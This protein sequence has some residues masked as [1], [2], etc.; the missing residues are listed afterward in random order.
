MGYKVDQIK[1][2]GARDSRVCISEFLLDLSL[3][4]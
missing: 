2:G 1:D 4:T 3:T